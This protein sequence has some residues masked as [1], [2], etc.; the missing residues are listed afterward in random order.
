MTT[1]QTSNAFQM[2][3][4]QI[5]QIRT[6]PIQR[7]GWSLS[8]GFSR[9]E[10]SEPFFGVTINSNKVI[11]ASYAFSFQAFDKSKLNFL[12]WPV[13]KIIENLIKGLSSEEGLLLPVDFNVFMASTFL[14]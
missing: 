7:K 2:T 1:D 9:S 14:A 5:M 12:L 13:M 11:F 6:E 4:C 10:L 3:L 8:V